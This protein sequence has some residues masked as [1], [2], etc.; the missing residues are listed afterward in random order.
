MKESMDPKH[1]HKL[2]K[3]AHKARQRQISFYEE[4]RPVKVEYREGEGFAVY[5]G[6]TPGGPD[7]GKKADP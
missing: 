4:V 6:K 7:E 2:A 5:A 1:L 3:A